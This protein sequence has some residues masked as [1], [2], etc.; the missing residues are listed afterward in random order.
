MTI[1]IQQVT[2]TMAPGFALAV[3]DARVSS[4]AERLL[5]FLEELESHLKYHCPGAIV[6]L[7]LAAS[8]AP[9]MTLVVEP[10]EATPQVQSCIASFLLRFGDIPPASPGTRRH[11]DCD[12]RPPRS[13][14][15]RR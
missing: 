8:T 12:R 2:V 1:C 15:A 5:T 11:S 6:A 4:R 13:T 3:H 7:R 14:H 10:S 9:P